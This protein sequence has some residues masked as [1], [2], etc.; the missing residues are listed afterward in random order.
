MIIKK[1]KS[2]NLGFTFLFISR[3]LYKGHLYLMPMMLMICVSSVSYAYKPEK[4]RVSASTGP[5]VFYTDMQ[6][7]PGDFFDRPRFGWSLIA[8]GVF[9]KNSGLE[10]GLFYMEKP[11]L[12]KDNSN[13]LVQQIKRMHITTGYRYW[14]SSYVSTAIGIFSAFS[15]GDWKD[16]HRDSGLPADFATS[17][18]VVTV[19]GMDTSLRL[20]FDFS[21][22]DGIVFDTRYALHFKPEDGERPNHLTFGIFYIRQIDVK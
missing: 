3:S 18:E 10:V 1:M 9:A 14:W 19:Y 8:E 16:D 11:Y 5:F 13:V 20:E 6:S 17:A 22:K 12:R 7:K 2:K 21:K 4:G 15:I